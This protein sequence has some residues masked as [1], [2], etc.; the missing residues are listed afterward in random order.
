MEG[1][2]CTLVQDNKHW[3]LRVNMPRETQC[4]RVI[5][6]IST[7]SG[8]KLY[9]FLDCAKAVGCQLLGGT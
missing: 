3:D 9:E 6:V 4:N 2:P 7:T 8:K 1:A 5:F